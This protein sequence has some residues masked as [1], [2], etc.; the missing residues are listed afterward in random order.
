MTRTS[1][2]NWDAGDGYG[3]SDWGGHWNEDGSGCGW[4]GG[5][6]AYEDAAFTGRQAPGLAVQRT[7]EDDEA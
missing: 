3:N 4:G 2:S 6:S 5:W 1:G 7:Y